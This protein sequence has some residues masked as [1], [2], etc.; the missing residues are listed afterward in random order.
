MIERN[1]S[2]EAPP[3]RVWSLL[4]DLHTWPVWDPDFVEVLQ[5]DRG[6]V[7][8]GGMI[9]ELEEERKSKIRFSRVKSNESF[10]WQARMI[11]GLIRTTSRFKLEPLNEGGATRL[12][13]SFKMHGLLGGMVSFLN[14]GAMIAGT[15]I[16][17]ENIKKLAEK[18]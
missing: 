11:F 9:M 18:N 3:E 16:G 10:V 4:A 7:E 8:G 13:Y 15:E 12:T 14:P 6:L 5:V 2:I 17:L 1:A